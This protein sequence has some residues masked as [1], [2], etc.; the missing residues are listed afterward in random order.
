MKLN[1]RSIGKLGFLL[2][3]IGYLMP[4]FGMKLII[5]SVQ[6]NGFEYAQLAMEQGGA[7]TIYGILMY[8][9]L[10]FAI[11]GLIIGVLLLAKKSAPIFIDWLITL[12]CIA[13]ILFFSIDS[14]KDGAVLQTGAYVIILGLIIAFIFQIISAIKKEE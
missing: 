13:G 3:I 2:V 8:G 7:S 12:A 11:A 5:G 4:M 10:I 1:F 9:L 14:T 6:M